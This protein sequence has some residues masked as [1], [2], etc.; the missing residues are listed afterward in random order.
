VLPGPP[1]GPPS[2]PQD[3]GLGLGRGQS[4]LVSQLAAAGVPQNVGL[5]LEGT[6]SDAARKSS[7]V[8]LGAQEFPPASNTA[9]LSPLL[10]SPDEGLY[11]VE[12]SD[13]Q[14]GHDPLGI[15]GL[16]VG[17]GQGVPGGAG[18]P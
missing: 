1:G 8:L 17:R 10:G 9:L 15:Q 12:V 18:R 4:S 6:A 2:A 11:L 3:G 14:V 5:C 13:S 7:H 16:R